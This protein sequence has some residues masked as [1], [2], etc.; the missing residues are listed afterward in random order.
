MSVHFSGAV[1]LLVDS[2][3]GE[4]LYV[5]FLH[6]SLVVTMVFLKCLK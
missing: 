3:H 5:C 4:T 1:V 6:H 2:V